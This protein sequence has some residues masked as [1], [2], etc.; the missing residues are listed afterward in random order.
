[1]SCLVVCVF[2][3]LSVST[4][5]QEPPPI[6]AM[7]GALFAAIIQALPISINDNLTVPIGSAIAMLVTSIIA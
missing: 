4:C 1:M 6:I 2:A 5:L 7:V 3:G